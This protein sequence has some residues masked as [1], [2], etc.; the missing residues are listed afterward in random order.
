MTE[1]S[2]GDRVAYRPNVKVDPWLLE[3]LETPPV[4]RVI[5]G[6]KMSQDRYKL[7]VLKPA[8]DTIF[9]EPHKLEDKD[10]YS[11]FTDSLE[12]SNDE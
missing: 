1:F 11:N 12:V 4:E 5:N 7:K 3:V 10:F 8:V 2:K 6:Q 9:L